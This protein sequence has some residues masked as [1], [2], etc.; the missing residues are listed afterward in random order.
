MKRK[1]KKKLETQ[2]LKLIKKS[3][4]K[5][6]FKEIGDKLN[7]T[8]KK[9]LKTLKK[10]LRFLKERGKLMSLQNSYSSTNNYKLIV[11]I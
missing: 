9:D 7:L 2:V 8:T 10:K 1:K 4:S 11:F 3:T 6:S 5:M